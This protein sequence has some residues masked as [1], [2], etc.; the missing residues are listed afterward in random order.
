MKTALIV[1]AS[2]GIGYEFV[3]QYR[4]AGWRVLAT[5]R[6]DTAALAVETLGAQ[7]YRLDVTRAEE[8][9][10]LAWQLDGEQIDVALIVS[11]VFGPRTAGAEIISDLDFDAV[12]HVNV[13]APM[14]M[15]PIL[16]PLVEA[17]GGTLAV[18]SSR[19]G[20]T[21]LATGADGWMYRVSKAALNAA[22][23]IVSLEA[24]QASCIALH[25]GWVRTG[26]GGANAA[27]DVAQSVSG[28][29]QVLAQVTRAENGRFL[30]YDG[31]EL[32]W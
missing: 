1:G 14:Q 23:K 17:V 5:V 15:I 13:R 24:R 6:D 4:E 8:I 16:L 2:R 26:M 20:S 31:A 3:R 18:V 10:G 27:L 19:M 32:P 29:R 7:S 12:M 9:A 30:Q 11:C 28:M 21:T 22:L 25:P